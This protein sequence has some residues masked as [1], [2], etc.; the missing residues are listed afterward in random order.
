MCEC[1]V[2]YRKHLDAEEKN[3]TMLITILRRLQKLYALAV[4]SINKT[5]ED[6]QSSSQVH[7]SDALD[8][9]NQSFFDAMAT[10]NKDS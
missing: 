4:K 7:P 1:I 2:E 6:M 10:V 5:D 3:L 8:K 9:Y